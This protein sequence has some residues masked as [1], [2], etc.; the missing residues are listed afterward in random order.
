MDNFIMRRIPLSQN[1]EY[2]V[3]GG[4]SWGGFAHPWTPTKDTTTPNL[5]VFA[6]INCCN[7]H[8]FLICYHLPLEVGELLLPLEGLP[9]FR[10]AVGNEVLLKGKEDECAMLGHLLH[11]LERGC[12]NSMVARTFALMDAS[13]NF[14][15]DL[16]AFEHGCSLSE[17][18]TSHIHFH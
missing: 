18:L 12:S 7:N 2:K 8:G 15:Y 16:L 10:N 3:S 13:F 17:S 14:E 4:L 9:P 11:F 6:C 1:I 5:S